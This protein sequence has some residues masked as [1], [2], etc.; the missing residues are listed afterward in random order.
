MKRILTAMALLTLVLVVAATSFAAEPPGDARVRVAH[1]SPDAPNVDVWV[2]G[3]Y[4]FTDVAFEDITD[5]A[6]LPA[7]P[8]H[9]RLDWPV[10]LTIAPLACVMSAAL[11]LLFGTL[12]DPR[13][14]PLLFGIV[15]IPLTFL[16]CIYFP[17]AQL[18]SIRWLQVLVLVNPLVYMSEGFRAALTPVPHMRLLAVY[19]VLLGFTVAFSALGL[20]TFRNRVLS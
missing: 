4:A 15:V 18:E 9:L 17:W 3:N 1:L 10:L 7:A 12:F 2:D 16:G 11:G 5:Y 14:V 20:R 19:P 6:T 13:T 8:V